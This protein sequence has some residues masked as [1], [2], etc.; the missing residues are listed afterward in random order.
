MSFLLD[1]ALD[2]DCTQAAGPRRKQRYQRRQSLQL[3]CIMVDT[4]PDLLLTP[5]PTSSLFMSR[6][7][8]LFLVLCVLANTGSSAQLVVQ[9]TWSLVLHWLFSQLLHRH[10]HSTI[11][12]PPVPP[13]TNL[14]LSRCRPPDQQ[15]CRH[16]PALHSSPDLWPPEGFLSVLKTSFYSVNGETENKGFYCAVTLCA[17]LWTYGHKNKRHS[18][19]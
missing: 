14:W 17:Y 9:P 8:K 7:S 12:Q 3:P 15:S 16:F 10:A 5:Q 6:V 2:P 18:R 19:L 1:P 11:Q 13:V 4:Q